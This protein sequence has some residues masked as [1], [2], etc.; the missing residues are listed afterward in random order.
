MDG[1]ITVQEPIVLPISESSQV[2]EARRAVRDIAAGAG[3]SE[4]AAARAALI[5][6]EAATNLI[7]HGGGGHMIFRVHD[8]APSRSVDVIAVDRGRGMPDMDECLRDGYSTAGTA[9]NGLGAIKRQ[10][11]AFDAYSRVGQGTVVF[12]RVSPDHARPAHVPAALLVDGLSLRISGEEVCGDAWAVRHKPGGAIV[13]VVDGLGHGRTANEAAMSA[14]VAFEQAESAPI[15]VLD[16]VHR[17]LLKTRGAAAAVAAID[18]A[19]GRVLYGGVGNVAA[20]IL[21]DGPARHLVSVHGTAGHQVRRMQEFTYDWS[22][23]SVLVMHSDG[24]S[25]H[26]KYDRYPG[27]W[28][29]HPVVIAAVLLRDWGRSHDDATVVVARHAG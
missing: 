9:G 16:S 2:A 20:T 1:P 14:L 22:G 25:A 4:D 6:T 3:L 13:L 8:A 12:A 18:A 26:I 27:L 24:V 19:Q 21:S 5:A 17:A 29:R 10:A 23:A 15:A 28:E 11:S 7:K